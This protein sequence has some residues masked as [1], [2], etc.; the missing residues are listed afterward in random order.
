MVQGRDERKPTGGLWSHW[1][2]FRKHPAHR[3]KDADFAWL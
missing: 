1:V 3:A 2:A